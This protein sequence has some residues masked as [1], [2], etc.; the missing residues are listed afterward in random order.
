MDKT[1][2]IWTSIFGVIGVI[3]ATILMWLC[4]YLIVPNIKD[5]TDKLFKW[6]DYAIEQEQDKT[7]ETTQNSLNTENIEVITPANWGVIWKEIL[8]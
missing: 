2:I 8:F 6:N 4:L 5:G 3:V 7:T 1:K